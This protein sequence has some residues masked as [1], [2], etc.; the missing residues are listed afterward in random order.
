MPPFHATKSL[1]AFIIGWFR[2]TR[3]QMATAGTPRA[4]T[5]AL[6]RSL[7]LAVFTWGGAGNLVAANDARSRYLAALRAAD[8]G[9]Y[10]LLLVFVRS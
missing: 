4:M 9:D 5:D 8:R 7:G 6:Q 2:S 10:G 1:P 3:F